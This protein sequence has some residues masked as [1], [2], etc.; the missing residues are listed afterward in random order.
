MPDYAKKHLRSATAFAPCDHSSLGLKTWGFLAVSINPTE[1]KQKSTVLKNDD[2]E[3]NLS[4][5]Y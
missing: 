3:K 1:N 2:F 5:P 4:K